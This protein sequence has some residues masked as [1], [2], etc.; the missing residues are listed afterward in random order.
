MKPTH[1][2]SGLFMC[3]MCFAGSQNC[4]AQTSKIAIVSVADTTVIYHHVGLTVFTN[5]IDT[6]HLNFSMIGQM[7]KTLHSYLDSVYSVKVVQLPDS[8]MK[9]KNGFFSQARTKKIKQWIR[10]S[11]DLYDFVIVIDN[12]GL[13]ENDRPMRSNTSGF[14]SRISYISY[15]STI[16][17]FG[18][19][20]SNLKPL[21]YYNQG[22]EFLKPIKNFKLPEDRRSFTP[23]MRTFLYD[24]FKN[25]LNSRVEY[26]LAKSYL[27]PQDKIDAIKAEAGTTKQE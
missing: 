10:S 24:G 4:R 21:E 3:F 23:E 20:T 22:G 2:L 19:R 11:K 18:Y 12:M 14:F 26:F 6:L 25:Y 1:L 7:E 17:F 27:I 5:F 9:V 13:S 8:V 15:Y 16:S